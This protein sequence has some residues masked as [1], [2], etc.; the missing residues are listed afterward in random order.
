MTTPPRYPYVHVHVPAAKAELAS[1]ELWVLGAQGVEERDATT[2][3]Q[4][5]E[6]V[7]L[8]ASFGDEDL[9]HKAVAQL[10]FPAR[11]EFVVGDDWR[12][13]WKAYF[14]P[15]EIGERLLLRPSWCEVDATDRTILTIDPG[16]AFGSG[17]HETTRLVLGEVDA[18]LKPG[19]RVLD[20]GCGSGILS[21]AALLLGAEHAIGIDVDAMAIDVARE[22]AKHNGV[23]HAFE[24][25][26][27]PI[28]A[29]DG[30]FP[31]ILANIQAPILIAM[32]DLLAARL[33]EGGVL[34]LSGILAGQEDDV[35]KAFS[36]LTRES[37]PA[38]NE[39]RAIVLTR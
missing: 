11:V 10:R 33:E 36:T 2:L 16:A 30:R 24:A 21:I 26:T 3:L 4:N 39:W 7:L 25:S 8:V 13:A 31:F 14:H 5:E 29:I 27:A 1:D 32:A 37:T 12:D 38:E 28:D 9:A 20:V 34:I 22:N 18:R 15:T 6:G 35:A 19:V 23:A 17:I